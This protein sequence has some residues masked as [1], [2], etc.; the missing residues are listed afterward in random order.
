MTSDGLTRA[1]IQEFISRVKVLPGCTDISQDEA[2]KAAL[3]FLRARKH[4][5]NR[6]VELYKAN[7]RMRYT[8]NVDTIDPLDEGVR[9]ELLSGKFTVL[10]SAGAVDDDN[11][12]ATVAIFTASRHWPPLTTHRDT[13]KGVLYQLDI[14]MMDEQSQRKGLIVLYDMRDAKYANFDYHLCIKLLNLFKGIYPARL[15]KVIIVE[16]PMW[17][18]APFGV[19]RLFVKEKMRDRI[20]TVDFDELHVHLTPSLIQRVFHQLTRHRHY[21]WLRTCLEKSGHA[22]QLPP[23]YFVTPQ[24]VYRSLGSGD[25]L[26]CDRNSCSSFRHDF[27]KDCAHQNRYRRN[28]ENYLSAI[29]SASVPR[30]VL[31]ADNGYTQT[32]VP[33]LSRCDSGNLNRMLTSMYSTVHLPTRTHHSIHS[34]TAVDHFGRRSFRVSKFRL[35][36]N[37]GL[38]SLSSSKSSDINS[39]DTRYPASVEH[40]NETDPMSPTRLAVPEFIARIQALGSIGLCAEFE[41]LFKDRPVR[42][43][44]DRFMLADNRRRNRYLDVPCLDSTAVEL[45]DGTYLHANWVHGYRSPRAYI[46][47][48]GPL[49]CT[50][51]DFWMA[52]WEH[53]VPVIVMLTKIVEGQRVKCAPYWPSRSRLFSNTSSS[54]LRSSDTSH[55]LAMGNSGHDLWST[56]L[57]E[58]SGSS[59]HYGEFQV[60]NIGETMEADGLYRRTRLSIRRRSSIHSTDRR[61]TKRS[62]YSPN[63]TSSVEL[64]EQSFIVDHLFYLGWPDFDVPSDSN[65]FLTFLS[66]VRQ[67]HQ[68]RCDELG[69]ALCTTVESHTE[70]QV[71]QNFPLLIH[72]SAGIGRTGTFVT[73][74]ICLQQAINEGFLDVPDVVSRL[75]DQRAGAVQVPKQYAFIHSALSSSLTR[76]NNGTVQTSSTISPSS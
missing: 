42:G 33:P 31:V 74:D 71:P 19:L 52:V 6:A 7:K 10:P 12:A 13:L 20:S 30:H 18:R 68:A 41:S 62:D 37:N 63:S 36:N 34:T 61:S 50:R 70:H 17:F 53:R 48:Q 64:P 1:E 16:A 35:R 56:D 11:Q 40:L 73:V 21:D 75:R 55:L 14:A 43:S 54:C 29:Q 67:L 25:I 28:S 22:A 69:V 45:S 47:A 8:E 38:H 66:E 51:R 9:K 59:A 76:L 2:E 26:Q 4:D 5:I 57:Q 39:T 32:V 3:L 65:G 58:D 15:R 49:D 72:C 27:V 24:P 46:L 23:D 60:I 44:C